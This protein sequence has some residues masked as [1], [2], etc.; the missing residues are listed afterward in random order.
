MKVFNG[1]LGL[2][3]FLAAVTFGT[4]IAA[5]K[6]KVAAPYYEVNLR[7]DTSGKAANQDPLL[8]NAW[9]LASLGAGDD[10]WINDEGSGVSELVDGQGKLFASLPSVTIPAPAGAQGPSTPTG[11]VA[12]PMQDF[13]LPIGGPALF[14]FDTIDGTIAAWNSAY[15]SAAI[16]VANNSGKAVYTGLAIA[17]SGGVPFLYAANALGSVD[18]FD[19]TFAPAHSAGGF[20][21]PNLPTGLAPYGIANIGG[22]IFVTYAQRG[23]ATGAVDEFDPQGNLIRRFATGGTLNA[24]WAVMIAPKN[25]GSLSNDLLIGNFGD[26]TINSFAPKTGKFLGQVAN[27]KHQPIQISGLW[28]LMAGAGVNGVT[29]QNAV[30]FTA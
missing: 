2:I 16:V 6:P 23:V 13:M 9:G 4:A 15:N 27:S 11:M 29:H 18:V 28:A 22:N 19:G 25:F 24:P 10:F 30:Y 20:A 17:T 1:Y 8:I 7:S 12:N 5:A 26:G 21:D 14:I 3:L